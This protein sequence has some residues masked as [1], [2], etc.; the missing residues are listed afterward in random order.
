MRRK[1]S[2]LIVEDDRILGFVTAEALRSRGHTV[3][4]AA[5][6]ESAAD[7]LRRS[8]LF[9]AML[10]DLDLGT[11]RGEALIERLRDEGA[12]LPEIVILSA[13]PMDL[14]HRS[15]RAIDACAVIQKPASV[16]EIDRELER[17]VPT[18]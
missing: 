5:T 16:E 15:R 14:L 11:E 1:F 13:Q 2:L 7:W 10:L 12:R 4:L 8:P 17:C 6:P 3:V 9:D 18:N